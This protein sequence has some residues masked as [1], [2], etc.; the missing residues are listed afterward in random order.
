MQAKLQNRQQHQYREGMK[1]NRTLLAKAVPQALAWVSALALC[2]AIA[3]AQNQASAGG[4]R[5]D[6]QIEMDVVHALDASNGLK[7]DL[8]TAST[9][10]SKV[11]LSGTVSSEAGRELAELIAGHVPG[12]TKVQND[13][14]VGNP[15]NAQLAPDAGD[16]FPVAQQIVDG[17][18]NDSVAL[19]PAPTA[20]TG[21][22]TIPQ[23]TLLQLRTSEPVDSKWAKDGTPVQFI[24]IRDVAY[25]GVLAIPRR[26]TRSKPTYSRSRDRIRR[27]TRYATP[28]IQHCWAP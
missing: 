20:P 19:A 23:G 7:K 16:D 21:P 12:V 25:G 10:Q 5:T 14:K 8:I 9:I 11:A 4:Q 22:V 17:P 13:L 26:T 6:G 1:M 24:V 2:G 3:M 18:P 28:L 15:Q 27:S